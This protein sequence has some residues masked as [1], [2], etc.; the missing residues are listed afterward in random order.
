[1]ENTKK[2]EKVKAGRGA[3]EKEKK[4]AELQKKLDDLNKSQEEWKKKIEVG[5]NKRRELGDRGM[6]LKANR[7][8]VRTEQTRKKSERLGLAK[9][10]KQLQQQMEHSR[11]VSRVFGV[12]F[13]NLMADIERNMT[14]FSAPPVG[15]VGRHIKLVGQAARDRDLCDL[16]ESDLGRG[17]L[18]SFIVNTMDDQREL[19]G[20]FA[21]HL[22]GRAQLSN[23]GYQTTIIHF[24]HCFMKISTFL[25]PEG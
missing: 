11:N 18:R 1:M 9:S 3:Q 21:R 5:G 14:K 17:R 20:I 2:A 24:I 23:S 7:S 22:Q 19:L 12:E 6:E 8:E 10:L 16:I 15:P 4:T 13:E 25:V